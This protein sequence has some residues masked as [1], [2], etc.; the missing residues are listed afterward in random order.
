[1]SAPMFLAGPAEEPMTADDWHGVIAAAGA[2]PST[3]NTQPWLFVV[4]S[5]AVELHLDPDRT[6]PVADSTGRGARISCGAALFNLQLAMRAHGVEPHV[7][8][9]PDR[10]DPTMLAVVRLRGHRAP[11]RSEATLYRAIPR[12]HSHRHPLHPAPVA[13]SAL[14]DVVYAAGIE[15]GYLRLVTDSPNAG[16][17]A[18]LIR[19]ADREQCADPAYQAELARWTRVGEPHPDSADGQPMRDFATDRPR[20][21]RE[22]ERGPLLGVLMSPGDTPR[23]HLRSGQALQR[24]LLTATEHGIGASIFSAPIE[25]AG[26]RYALRNLTGALMWPQLVLRFGSAVPTA[27]TPRRPVAEIAAGLPATG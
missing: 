25:V 22:F 3:H 15:G 24:A 21:I 7:A 9:T 27:A 6:L 17:V 12:R 16:V 5:D 23:D 14:N 2:A 13:R 10:A 26:A 11:T 1:M 8:L 19:R 20:P 18:A 4:R